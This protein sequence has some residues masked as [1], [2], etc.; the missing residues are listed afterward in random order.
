MKHRFKLLGLIV[1]IGIASFVAAGSKSSGTKE[2]VGCRL[3]TEVVVIFGLTFVQQARPNPC[4]DWVAE[5]NNSH[6]HSW[7]NTGCWYS[8]F[9]VSCSRGLFPL[10]DGWL[11][12]LK[13]LPPDDF[14]SMT[15]FTKEQGR[16]IGA[17]RAYEEWQAKEA[18]PTDADSP[19]H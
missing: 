17:S 8:E 6:Q 14:V 4:S 9:G 7:V 12:Y 5:R 11:E 18:I 2:C 15:E 10:A 3:E 19:R 16:G 13:T 1:T